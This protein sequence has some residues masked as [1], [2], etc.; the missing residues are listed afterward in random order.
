M[1]LIINLILKITAA[2][3]H[4]MLEL[5]FLVYI[6][7]YTFFNT[8]VT[9]MISFIERITGLKELFDFYENGFEMGSVNSDKHKSKKKANLRVV[10]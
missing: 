4:L 8:I 2:V 6:I 9:S 3:M 10:E 5:A 7:F 1:S